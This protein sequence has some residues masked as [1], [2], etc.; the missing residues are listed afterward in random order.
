MEPYELPRLL[1]IQNNRASLRLKQQPQIHTKIRNQESLSENQS[2]RRQARPTNNDGK[3]FANRQV[4]Y[5][6][7]NQPSVQPQGFGPTP[8]NQNSGS[9]EPIAITPGQNA[10]FAAPLNQNSGRRGYR[11]NNAV[12]T[13]QGVRQPASARNQNQL[14]TNNQTPLGNLIALQ[15][16]NRSNLL[17][18]NSNQF[19]LTPP[20]AAHVEFEN[21]NGFV[22]MVARNATVADVLNVLAEKE[23][24][25]FVLSGQS[26]QTIS[27]SLK[28]IPAAQA[29][30]SILAISGHSWNERGGIV[31]VQPNSSQGTNNVTPE[32]SGKIVKVFDLDYASATNISEV[33]AGM[34]SAS[35][36]S[37]VVESDTKD[38]R[39]T[40]EQIVVEDYPGVVDRVQQYIL[41]ADKPPRQVLIEAVVL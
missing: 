37:Y 10:S 1:P 24:I 19:L 29:L 15:K 21:Q 36:K 4:A 14:Q 12:P 31:Y 9:G 39:K 28:K 40:D 27:F 8:T 34:L 20:K 5:Q 13:S 22:T 7:S 41:Q 2:S 11:Q 26:A 30:T 33:V 17:S 6:D 16:G 3:T 35:G 23:N 32:Y 18:P 25:S 38:I